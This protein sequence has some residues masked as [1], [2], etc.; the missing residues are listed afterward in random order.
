[1]F[2]LKLHM[3]RLYSLR[4]IAS[5]LP[6][7]RSKGTFIIWRMGTAFKQ[8][9]GDLHPLESQPE[10][11]QDKAMP[12]PPKRILRSTISKADTQV[13]PTSDQFKEPGAFRTSHMLSRYAN[14]GR[15]LSTGREGGSSVTREHAGAVFK[16]LQKTIF[17]NDPSQ[18]VDETV[19]KLEPFTGFAAR[20]GDH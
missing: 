10:K 8:Q 16:E 14:N 3:P 1:M 13:K 4:E 7:R 2:P 11:Q 6:Q 12:D 17:A 9:R 15:Y 19:V 20:P 5:S 18:A